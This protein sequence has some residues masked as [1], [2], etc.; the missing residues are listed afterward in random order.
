MNAETEYAPMSASHTSVLRTSQDI[1]QL[2]G[3]LAAAQGEME[4][5]GKDREVTVR[6]QSGAAYSYSYATLD[7]IVASV[8]PALARNGLSVVQPI[9][10][11]NRTPVLL[12]RVMHKSGQWMET[13]MEIVGDRS[14]PQKFGSAVTYA[15]R[16][17]L[18][19]LLAIVSDD[20]DDGSQASGSAEAERKDRV[21]DP[22]RQQREREAA[23]KAPWQGMAWPVVDRSGRCADMRTSEA[24]AAEIKRRVEVVLRLDTL[25]AATKR[26]SVAQQVREPLTGVLA[27]LHERGDG[28]AADAAERYL[29]DAV[30]AEGQPA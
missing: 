6:P 7:N 18:T 20:D 24:W 25:D 21:P 30:P 5:P 11:V 22:P 16:Q 27:M 4:M 26:R 28:D 13:A 29:R 15:R 9:V 2:A 14:T 19:S 23:A 17:S 8:R 12:T 3:A 1:D 10:T